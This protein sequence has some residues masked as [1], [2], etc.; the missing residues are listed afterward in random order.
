MLNFA[1]QTLVVAAM[2][3]IDNYV[4]DSRFDVEQDPETQVWFVVDR[5]TKNSLALPYEICTDY[6]SSYL[7]ALNAYNNF[8]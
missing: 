5:V 8:H 6:E 3:S 1:Q 7:F 2:S 4:L